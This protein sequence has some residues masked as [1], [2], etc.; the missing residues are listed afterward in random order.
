MRKCDICKEETKEFYLVE[1][2]CEYNQKHV[3][4]VCPNCNETLQNKENDK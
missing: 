3:L 2:I 1:E 4:E